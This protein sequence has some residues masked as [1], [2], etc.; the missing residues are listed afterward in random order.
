M[1][2]RLNERD[3]KTAFFRNLP[4]LIISPKKFNHLFERN[5]KDLEIEWSEYTHSSLDKILNKVEKSLKLKKGEIYD[6]VEKYG[7][8]DYFIGNVT[9]NIV[10]ECEID[11]FLKNK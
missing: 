6:A 9:D 7:L 11:N 10:E 3:I 4:S 2:N 1:N 8:L 5:D